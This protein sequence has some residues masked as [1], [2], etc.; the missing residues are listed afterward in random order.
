MTT[1]WLLKPFPGSRKVRE[2]GPMA[3]LRPFRAL[4]PRVDLAHRVAAPPY[5][6]LDVAEAR[7]I[8]TDNPDSF[9]HVSRPEIDLPDGTAA[10]SEPVHAAGRRALDNMIARGVLELDQN[11]GYSIYSQRRGEH[12][13]TGVVACAAVA[14]YLAGLIRTHEHTRPDKETDRVNHIEA[15]SAHDEPVFLLTSPHEPAWKPV[16]DLIARVTERS[17]LVDLEAD[18]GVHHVLW[19]V[20][21]QEE[22][23]ELQAHLAGLPELYVADGHHRSA[24]ATRVSQAHG[25]AGESDAFLAVLFPGEELAVLPYNRVVADLGGRSPQQWLED[26]SAVFDLAPTAGPV[27][28]GERGEFGMYCAGAWLQL[29][30]REGAAG[31]DR[32]ADPVAGLDVSLLQDL[33]LGPW[34][35]ITDPRTDARIGFVG[36][37]RG[38]EELTRLVDSGAWAAAFSLHP[39]SVEELVAVAATGRDMPPKSTWFEPKLRSGLVVHRF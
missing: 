26:L 22:V 21:E 24:A 27:E 4:R 33:V 38:T 12:T 28:A 8:A 9:L 5:D 39:T 6:V 13:Q 18:D 25:G 32:L 30:L 2:D 34:L 15:L 23:A 17:P 37:I 35:G 19:R 31:A 20:G 1:G 10:D 16:A 11:H 14:D 3:D 36:G 29:Q 7:A